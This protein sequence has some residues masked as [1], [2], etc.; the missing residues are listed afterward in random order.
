MADEDARNTK[1]PGYF[2]D[3]E[4]ACFE[5]LAVFWGYAYLVGLHSLFE[6]D[7]LVGIRTACMGIIPRGL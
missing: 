4:I 1:E 6:N 7:G 5:K 3:L 2:F